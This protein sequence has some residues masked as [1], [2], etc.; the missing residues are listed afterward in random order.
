[1]G[2]PA[3]GIPAQQALA[4]Q[5]SAARR[6]YSSV[7]G[8]AARTRQI[9]GKIE[10]QQNFN[11]DAAQ[12]GDWKAYVDSNF[13]IQEQIANLDAGYQV[14]FQE[15]LAE[16]GGNIA[17][18][19]RLLRSA[20]LS[21][22][23]VPPVRSSRGYDYKYRALRRE[24]IPSDG[25]FNKVVVAVEELPA[26]FAYEA[27]PEKR[28]LAFLA[29]RIRNARR[30]PYL[31]GPASVFLGPDFI[32][33]GRIPTTARGEEFRV[34]LGADESIS[35]KRRAER[36]RETSGLFTSWH[37]YLNEVEVTV[38]NG[39]ARPVKVTVIE[40]VPFTEDSKVTVKRGEMVPPPLREDRK[41][42]LAWD[43]DLRPGEERKVTLGWTVVVH[44]D[45]QAV[46]VE[47][48]SVQW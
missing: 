5:Q 13:A 19:Q 32:G 47:D 21:D 29:S 3:E 28:E 11:R 36:K 4:G 7:G 2:I 41:G 12:K 27:A 42:L 35:V 40:R 23:L 20:R 17:R 39:K 18:G 15:D 25:A 24:S 14:L 16:A 10:S 6:G 8:K 9:L 44:A 48:P 45:R 22:G 46:G 43:L 31:E 38:K 1:M 33:D 26:D 30:Q 34:E 37:N